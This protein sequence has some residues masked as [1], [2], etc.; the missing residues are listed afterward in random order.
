MDNTA[1]PA[2]GR[3][4]GRGEAVLPQGLWDELSGLG[5]DKQAD[6][7]QDLTRYDDRPDDARRKEHNFSENFDE[8]SF[9]PPMGFGRGRGGARGAF[10][11][12]GGGGRGCGL[13]KVEHWCYY[14][15]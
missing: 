1:P 4:R 10:G 8:D 2:V 7:V 11:G 9:I 13:E 12:R 5:N 3:G 6:D 14:I 15:Y